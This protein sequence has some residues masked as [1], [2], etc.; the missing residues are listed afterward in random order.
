MGLG[1][2]LRLGPEAYQRLIAPPRGPRGGAGNHVLLVQLG[3]GLRAVGRQMPPCGS[4]PCAKGG[5]SHGTGPVVLRWRVRCQ[6]RS[7]GARTA[8]L[9]PVL[10]HQGSHS[11]R[12]GCPASCV[13]GVQHINVAAWAGSHRSRSRYHVHRRHGQAV[14]RSSTVVMGSGRMVGA[15]TM[16]HQTALAG[17]RPACPARAVGASKSFPRSLCS[18]RPWCLAD[19]FQMAATPAWIVGPDI[20]CWVRTPCLHACFER[21]DAPYAYVPNCY[22]ASSSGLVAAST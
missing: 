13:W 2:R 21:I 14:A 8:L 9:P 18:R 17:V 5:R 15:T 1:Q 7:G 4:E 22:G 19:M 10:L 12:Q 3:E 6:Q 20:G 16:N 11:Q